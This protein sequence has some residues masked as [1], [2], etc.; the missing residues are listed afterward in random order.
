M[1][2]HKI[3]AKRRPNHAYTMKFAKQIEVR[4]RSVDIDKTVGKK[5][6]KNIEK[7]IDWK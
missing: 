3:A 2:I 4:I 1:A 5:I 6:N 7:T